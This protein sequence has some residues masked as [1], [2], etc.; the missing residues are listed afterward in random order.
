MNLG[1]PRPTNQ[2]APLEILQGRAQKRRKEEPELCYKGQTLVCLAL[3]L[4]DI[5]SELDPEDLDKKEASTEEREY[6]PAY[7][8]N[9]RKR[10]PYPVSH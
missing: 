5:V 10:M 3:S 7:G 4:R 6:L 8:R 9:S 2:F 1:R